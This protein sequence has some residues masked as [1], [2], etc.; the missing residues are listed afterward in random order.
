MKG[1]IANYGPVCI[2]N[3]AEQVGKERVI[4]EAF[5]QHVLQFDSDQVIYAVFDFHEH[6]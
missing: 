6:W 5:T 1:E 2:V 3:L 4:W